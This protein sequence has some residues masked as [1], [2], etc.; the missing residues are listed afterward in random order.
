MDL[1]P[2]LE[3]TRQSVFVIIRQIKERN[4]TNYEST[5]MILYSKSR[6]EHACL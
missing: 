1:N 6:V 3:A 5:P 2:S 4:V